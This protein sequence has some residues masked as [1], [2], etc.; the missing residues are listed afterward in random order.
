MIIL[1][2]TRII[3]NAFWPKNGNR[4]T[5]NDFGNHQVHPMHGHQHHITSFFPQGM[6]EIR[7]IGIGIG[8]GIEY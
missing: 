1:V 6:T 4:A 5:N 7:R 2:R 3:I 8:I